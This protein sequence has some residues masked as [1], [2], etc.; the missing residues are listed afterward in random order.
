MTTDTNEPGFV[1]FEMRWVV[2]DEDDIQSFESLEDAHEYGYGR[3]LFRYGLYARTEEGF[4]QHI[5]DYPNRSSCEA[6]MA[7]LHAARRIK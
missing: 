1:S 5:W 4:L 2:R 7:I 6:A 3:A